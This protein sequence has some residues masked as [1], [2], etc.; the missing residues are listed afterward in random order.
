MIKS[1][2][3]TI[4]VG[5]FRGF[6]WSY[7]LLSWCFF[8][9][10][11]FLSTLSF[12]PNLSS[13]LRIFLFRNLAFFFFAVLPSLGDMS[14][15][16]FHHFPPMTPLFSRSAFFGRF[17]FVLPG[18]KNCQ[19]PFSILFQ[20]AFTPHFCIFYVRLTIIL[21]FKLFVPV[22]SSHSFVT[23]SIWLLCLRI[24]SSLCII[25]GLLWLS[26]KRPLRYLLIIVS[27]TSYIPHSL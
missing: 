19:A 21:S 3:T 1:E 16:N 26:S 7:C 24:Q 8:S 18:R 15:F 13:A 23:V 10:G 9:L 11:F 2:E 14:A 20:L 6:V 17:F 5:I 25:T 12:F 4:D 27:S 22:Q